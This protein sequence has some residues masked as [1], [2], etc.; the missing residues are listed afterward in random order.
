MDDVTITPR[1]VDSFAPLIG[2]RRMDQLVSALAEARERLD[3]A[4][5]WHVNSTSAGGGVAEILQSVLSYLRGADIDVR[6]LVIDGSEAFFELTKRIHHLLHGSPGDDG[7]LDAEQRELY[8][9]T[10][11]NEE[12][13]LTTLVRPGDVVIL[14][15]P[16]V[17]GLAPCLA[18]LGAPVIWSCHIGADRPNRE[19]R[20]AWNFLAPYVAETNAQSFTRMQY[21][22]DTIAPS[23]VAVIPPCI[24][25]F[26]PKNQPLENGNVGAILDASGII[27][28]PERT[29]SPA[30]LRKDGSRGRVARRAQMIEDEHLV[31]DAPVVCQVSRWDPLKDHLGV[32]RAF[33][34]HISPEC[35]AQLV[36]AGPSTESVDDDPETRETFVELIKAWESLPNDDRRRVHL[37]SVPMDDIEENAATVNALQRRS[38]LIVQKSLAEGFGLTVAE[39]MWK[40]R[41]TVGSRVGG[42]QDQIEPGRSGLLVDPSD[43]SEFG[44]AVT[45]VLADPTGAAR[46]GQAGRRRVIEN[47]VAPTYLI[48]QFALIAQLWSSPGRSSPT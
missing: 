2:A 28:H 47:Y 15:D 45:S 40:G 21:R 39:A 44:A 17:L 10:L 29:G 34:S 14:H 32:M 30:F 3:G 31:P 5:V 37:C 19:T 20:R 9:R 13:T 6:W 42:I 18:T 36:L 1:S 25:A 7:P 26:A 22:W 46:M 4:T 27:P 8:E 12:K 33:V 23:T 35:Q 41:P 48:N 38:D 43:P 24:D 16:Q 11:R